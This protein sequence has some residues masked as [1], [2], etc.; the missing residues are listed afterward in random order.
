[1]NRVD[2]FFSF[3]SL[4]H[5]PHTH[6]CGCCC[7]LQRSRRRR[8][9]L[10]FLRQQR[11]WHSSKGSK[12]KTSRILAP[13][14]MN[15]RRRPIEPKTAAAKTLPRKKRN[16]RLSIDRFLILDSAP[17]RRRGRTAAMQRRRE[18]ATGRWQRWSCCHQG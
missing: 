2:C 1:M 4:P 14:N 16:A 13:P 12:A 7:C 11:L 6:C 5:A 9:Q 3:L 15:A 8:P 10:S 18:P 17:R